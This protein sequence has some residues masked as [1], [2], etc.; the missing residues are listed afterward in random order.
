VSLLSY[1][2]L[3]SSTSF[4]FFFSRATLISRWWR[5]RFRLRFISLIGLTTLQKREVRERL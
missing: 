2:R 3:L 5:R 1:L 4:T